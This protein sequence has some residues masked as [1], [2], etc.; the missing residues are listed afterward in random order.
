MIPA[1]LALSP[2]LLDYDAR[3]TQKKGSV[4]Q[5]ASEEQQ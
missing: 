1:S 4:L 3:A 2:G 5:V